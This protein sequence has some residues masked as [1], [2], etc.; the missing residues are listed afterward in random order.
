MQSSLLLQITRILAVISV[1]GLMTACNPKT[2][3]NNTKQLDIVSTATLILSNYYQKEVIYTGRVNAANT[4]RLS[5]ELAGKINLIA[6]DTGNKINK[7]QMIAT[8]DNQILNAKK[9][10]IDAKIIQNKSL[11]KLAESTLSR[12]NSLNKNAY[13]SAQRLDEV[14][15][16]QKSLLAA[17]QILKAS[18]KSMLLQ[19]DK[20]ILYAPFSGVISQRHCNLGEVISQGKPVFTLVGD[21]PEAYIGV[22]LKIATNL[23]VNQRV[24]V[25]INKHILKAHIAGIGAEINPITH[26]VEIRL[27][28]PNTLTVFNGQIANLRHQQKMNQS[29]FWVP[30]SALT[31]GIKGRWNMYLVKSN[32]NEA[33]IEKRDID[34]IYTQNNQ[35]YVNGAIKSGEQYINKGLHKF[36]NGQLV[37]LK[38]PKVSG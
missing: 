6:A 34:V 29:G 3:Q 26:T 31:E 10:E 32:L 28:L 23:T 4:T 7:G 24:S 12:S 1:L 38:P 5:F 36:V 30:I 25:E 14:K 17:Q 33:K 15:S 2:P 21:T 19:L 22:P 9:A 20:S 13:I 16:Q 35:A 27:S 11:L 8:L 18:R 37:K